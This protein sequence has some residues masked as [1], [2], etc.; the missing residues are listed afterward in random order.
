VTIVDWCSLVISGASL[1]TAI[2]STF[3]AKGCLTEAELARKQGQQTADRA[4]AD[5]AQQKWFDLYFKVDQAYNALERFQTA[6]HGCNTAT[7][8]PEQAKEYNQLM[9]I[10]R[11]AHTMAVVFPKNAAI[12]ALFTST[13]ISNFWSDVLPKERLQSL[14]DALELLRQKALVDQSVLL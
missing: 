3:I 11:E 12:D 2:A 13:K 9:H 4:H 8:F 5:W 7:L 1:V 10:I 14:S 6:N